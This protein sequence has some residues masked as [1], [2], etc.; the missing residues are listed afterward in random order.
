[1]GWFQRRMAS[2]TTLSMQLEWINEP[3]RFS[4]IAHPPRF[5]GIQLRRRRPA[6]L[7]R[8]GPR[9]PARLRPVAR[10]FSR[11]RARKRHLGC[12]LHPR[13]GPD[14]AGHVRVQA[15]AAAT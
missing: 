1:M 2:A 15:D 6:L 11:P 3:D 4:K 14:R 7:S 12:D 9:R 13:D 8:A 10:Y 5:A